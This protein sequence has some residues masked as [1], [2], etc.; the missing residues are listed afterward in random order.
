MTMTVT[1]CV[2]GGGGGGIGGQR[3]SK[4]PPSPQHIETTKGRGEGGGREYQEDGRNQ[5]DD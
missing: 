1:A 3:I 5:V 4:A 2:T